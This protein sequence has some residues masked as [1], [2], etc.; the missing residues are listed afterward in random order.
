[1]YCANCGKLTDINEAVCAACRVPLNCGED[2]CPECGAK[3]APDAQKCSHCGAD[4][5]YSIKKGGQSGE[6]SRCVAI[7]LAF[8]L[9]AFGAHNFY[10]GFKKYAIIQIVLTCTLVLSPF[11]VLWGIMDGV[12]MLFGK[13]DHDAL[14][15][16]LRK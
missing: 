4:A 6:K 1:M 7:V 10:L 2:F 11:T 13:R 3:L 15:Y 9:G 14:G 12:I 8:L 5:P 16:A